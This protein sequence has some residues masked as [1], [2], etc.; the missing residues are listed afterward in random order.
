MMVGMEMTEDRMVVVSA[1]QLDDLLEL[2]RRASD[3]LSGDPVGSALSGAR[4]EVLRSALL[5]P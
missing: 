5:E 2:A 1:R 3:R 4:A